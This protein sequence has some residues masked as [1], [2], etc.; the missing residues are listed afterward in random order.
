MMGLPFGGDAQEEKMA[1]QLISYYC[2]KKENNMNSEHG[3]DV[4]EVI[5]KQKLM[6]NGIDIDEVI[7]MNNDL[8]C[9]GNCI[10]YAKLD[11]PECKTYRTWK[12]ANKSCHQWTYDGETKQERE[13]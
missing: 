9:C 5:I 6:Y 4:D 3:I 8:C 1:T 12:T 11:C 2:D 13:L 7:K 10:L